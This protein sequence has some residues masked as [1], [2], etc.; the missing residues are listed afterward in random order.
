MRVTVTMQKHNL[1]YRSLIHFYSVFRSR[2]V[3]TISATGSFN[4]DKINILDK[5]CNV[6]GRMHSCFNTRLCFSATFRPNNPVGPVGKRTVRP[7]LLATR[8]IVLHLFFPSVWQKRFVLSCNG[9]KT[10]V[11]D[12]NQDRQDQQLLTKL[13]GC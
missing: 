9:Y 5:P 8:Q 13:A 11:S 7:L 4:P 2:G 1:L 10:A 6:N 12:E 3:A